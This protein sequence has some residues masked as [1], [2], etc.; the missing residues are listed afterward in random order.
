MTLDPAGHIDVRTL[1]VKVKPN[2]KTRALQEQPDGTWIAQVQA[3]PIDG[4]A[5]EALIALV[6]ET[7]DVRK[8]QVSI[9]SGASG[10]LKLVQ[11]AD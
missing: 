1:R 10:R 3:P 6:A 8:A 2:A 7:L 4:K 5:N 11:V 9:R